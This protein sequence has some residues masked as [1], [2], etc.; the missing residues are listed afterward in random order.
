LGDLETAS[1]IQVSSINVGSGEYTLSSAPLAGKTFCIWYWYL[2]DEVDNIDDTYF[3]PDVTAI[4][5]AGR[6]YVLERFNNRPLAQNFDLDSALTNI[7]R[8]FAAGRTTWTIT[9]TLSSLDVRV[10]NFLQANNES[11]EL[12]VRRTST[13]TIEIE[14]LGNVVDNT[15]RTSIKI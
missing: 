2:L 11:I 6:E 12:T 4:N 9:H 13:T 14:A 5:E 1:E 3:S 8:V 15:Y 10:N 7:T